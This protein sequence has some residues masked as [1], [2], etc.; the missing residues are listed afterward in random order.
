MASSPTILALWNLLAVA[1]LGTLVWLLTWAI[2]GDRDGPQRRRCPKCAHDMRGTAGLRCSECGREAAREASLHYRRRRWWLAAAS[3]LAILSL[4]AVLRNAWSEASWTTLIPDRVAI[5]MLPRID[6]GGPM[7]DAI[8]ELG[9]RLVRGRLSPADTERLVERVTIGDE[10]APPG[11]VAWE[12]KYGRMLSRWQGIGR[13][14]YLDGAS[15]AGSAAD[16]DGSALGRRRFVERI[17]RRVER[18]PP[19]LRIAAPWQW[20]AREPLSLELMAERPWGPSVP[21]RLIVESLR[22]GS[23]APALLPPVDG[24]IT[25]HHGSPVVARIPLRFEGVGPGMHEGTLRVRIEM[26]DD[27]QWRTIQTMGVPVSLVVAA[28]LRELHGADGASGASAAAGGDPRASGP[29]GDADDFPPI[30]SEQIDAAIAELLSP[31]L[32]RWARGNRRFALR[33]NPTPQLQE[34]L[35]EVAIGV[36]AEVLEDGVVRRRLRLWWPGDGR[37]RFEPP[38]EDPEALARAR[39]GDGRWTLRVRGDRELSLRSAISDRSGVRRHWWNG[40]I[41]RPLRVSDEEGDAILR[42]WTTVAPPPSP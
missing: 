8:D 42:A 7:S 3:L 6:P 15:A 10:R 19:I 40:Q 31:G 26:E 35:R 20:I 12:I 21:T 1:A 4:T 25:L 37:L 18:L 28:S 14:A 27:G 34:S 30:R 11:S 13:K 5:W 24:P 16:A 29:S 23:V 22:F 9:A 39:E 17:D 33:L 32:V 2:F 38:Q 36:E 41:E